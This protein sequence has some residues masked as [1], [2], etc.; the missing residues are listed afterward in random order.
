MEL[1]TGD[2][3]GDAIRLLHEKNVFGA[4]IAV[5]ALDMDTG[6]IGR[7][8]SDGYIGFIDF[9]RMVLW[10]LEVIGSPNKSTSFDPYPSPFQVRSF[11]PLF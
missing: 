3:L 5:D 4:P 11:N 1:K 7:K 9:A 6:T 2:C 8:F 10:S